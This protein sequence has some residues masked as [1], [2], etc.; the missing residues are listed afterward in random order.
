MENYV[1]IAQM[2]G[3]RMFA[4]A[5]SL[6]IRQV[7]SEK[8]HVEEY[9]LT[10]EQYMQLLDEVEEYLRQGRAVGSQTDEFRLLAKQ[11]GIEH[12]LRQWTKSP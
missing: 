2:S 1:E 10:A 7:F 5:E 3:Y 6:R 8:Q 11:R 12:E 9:H 4:D